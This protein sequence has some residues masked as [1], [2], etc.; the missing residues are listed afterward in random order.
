MLVVIMPLY[1]DEMGVIPDMEVVVPTGY[2]NLRIE[3][4]SH[5]DSSFGSILLLF[6]EIF[7]IDGWIVL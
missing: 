1:A 7:V 5:L 6:L 3:C 4:N 2:T